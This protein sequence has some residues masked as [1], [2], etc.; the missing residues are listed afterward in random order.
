MLKRKTKLF[1]SLIE[2]STST[3]KPIFKIVV[4]GNNLSTV[5]VAHDISTNRCR[6]DLTYDL[7]TVRNIEIH[8]VNKDPNDTKVQDN[9]I[10]E[11][12]L[13]VLDKISI[14]DIDLV[15]DLP[16]ISVYRNTDGTV[17][18]THNY[19]TFNGCMYIKIHKNLLFNKWLANH[20]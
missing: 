15:G 7:D 3:K 11:D 17:H 13:L 18:R 14:D 2:Q 4:D 6:R 1:L 19:I 5:G 8:F 9:K 16:L 20:C 12:L 10:V